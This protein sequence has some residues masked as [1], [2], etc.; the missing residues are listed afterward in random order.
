MPPVLNMPGLGIWQDWEYTKVTNGAEYAWI[1]LNMPK[2]YLNLCEYALIMLNILKDAWAYL[3]K[4]SSEY[5]RIMNASDVVHSISLLYKLLSSYWG[6]SVFNTVKLWRWSVLQKNI[7]SVKAWN[8]K[9][10]GQG[11]F[12]SNKEKTTQLHIYSLNG[13][14]N[15]KMDNQDIFL[16]K[17]EYISIFKKWQWRGAQ[18]RSAL[19]ISCTNVSAD[20]YESMFLNIP[21]YSCK[22]LAKCSNYARILNMHGYVTCSTDFGGCPGFLLCQSSKY[23]T[24]FYARVTQSSEYVWKW[25]NNHWICLNML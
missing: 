8:Q 5:A 16:P 12:Q 20:E 4:Y 2:K 17:S 7:A 23:G 21:K 9:F 3:N 18:W 24:V 25:L 14:F 1:S 15:L 10:S 22:M 6:R 11:R 13:E 19:L